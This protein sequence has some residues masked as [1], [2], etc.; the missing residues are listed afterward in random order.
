MEAT[1][2]YFPAKVRKHG[3]SE[4]GGVRHSG[5]IPKAPAIGVQ[6]KA[7]KSLRSVW[8]E[9]YVKVKATVYSERVSPAPLEDVLEDTTALGN[10]LAR[11]GS[12]SAAR[13]EPKLEK[14]R[15]NYLYNIAVRRIGNRL[16]NSFHRE[17][18]TARLA[19]QID[20]MRDTSCRGPFGW[21]GG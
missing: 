20:R 18:E 4:T 1:A 16:L 11:H 2:H 17:G 12:V 6:V 14:C 15:S 9:V 10:G 5:Q 8:T 21:S 13:L 7:R 19:M 3:G